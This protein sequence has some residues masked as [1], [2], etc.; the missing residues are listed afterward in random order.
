MAAELVLA[1]LAVGFGVFLTRRYPSRVRRLYNVIRAFSNVIL[2]VFSLATALVFLGS[3]VFILQVV[4]FAIVVWL[5][6]SVVFE[7]IQNPLQK[8]KSWMN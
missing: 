8:A 1:V 2:G 5:T 4:G 3:G 6:F 7:D